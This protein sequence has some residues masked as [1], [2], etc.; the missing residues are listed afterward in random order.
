MLLV[1]IV[2]GLMT[3][4]GFALVEQI[5]NL[6]RFI[7]RNIFQLPDLVANITEQ[8]YEIGP[9]SFS[10]SIINWNEIT[11]EIVRAIQPAIG[12]VGTLAG[13]IAAGAVNIITWAVLIV[14]ISY[15]LLAESETFLS[16]RFEN[17][18]TDYSRDFLRLGEELNRIWSAFIRGELV[19]VVI[20]YVI[21]TIML[22]ILGVQ[23]F[24]GLA[25]I[26]AVGQLIPYLGAWVT[27]I[28]FGLVAL[29]QANVPFDVPS[30]IY[31]IIVLGVSMV[32]N[33]IIDNIIRTKVMAS[34]L[35]VH[36][37][38]VLIGAIIGVQL[39]GFIG[40][41]IA[42]PMMASFKLFLTYVIRKLND[43]EPFKDLEI[44]KESEQS[45]STHW[46]K[47]IWLS[48]KGWVA[49]QWQRWVKKS[50]RTQPGSNPE[51]PSHQD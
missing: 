11:N 22:G 29:F 19:V 42:A 15:F 2:L 38:L 7:E 51:E 4:G 39:F 40:I 41:V 3:W 18:G 20:A 10:P 27:W 36:P 34:G 49:T 5:Q 13:S 16:Q 45:K 21:Y 26:A 30:G 23:F 46:L 33:N 24:A 50:G 12:R 8:T 47:R 28:S 9:F 37:S 6:I 25:A 14:L 43:Q 35:K 48:V 32:A 17:K 44:Q 1:V 31:M